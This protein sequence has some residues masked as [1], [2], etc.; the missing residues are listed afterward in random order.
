V[1][2]VSQDEAVAF[3]EWLTR[4]EREAGRLPDGFAYRLPSGDE[5]TVLAQ[6]GD[7]REFP[8]GSQWPP[9]YGNYADMTARPLLGVFIENYQDHFDVS[10]PVEASG[11]NTW[12]LCGVGGNVWEWTEESR[13]RLRLARGGS[14]EDYLEDFLTCS[15]R[16]ELGASNRTFN[17]GFR[18]ILGPVVNA[19]LK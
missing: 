7:Q 10:C 14:W 13:G 3:G 8:W 4:R 1:V 19:V 9:R 15:F 18:M 11:S 6:C 16:D 17:V 5:W 12:G 2:Y